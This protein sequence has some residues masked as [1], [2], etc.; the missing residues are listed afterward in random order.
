MRIFAF[1][2]MMLISMSSFAYTC[3]CTLDFRRPDGFYETARANAYCPQAENRWDLNCSG[4]LSGNTVQ[5]QCRNYKTGLT[6]YGYGIPVFNAEP[7]SFI[8]NCYLW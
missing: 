3:N 8:P 6:A 7:V 2:S 1:L 5:A 4:Y